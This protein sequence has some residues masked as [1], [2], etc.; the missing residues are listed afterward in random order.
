MR[1]VEKPTVVGDHSP[2]EAWDALRADPS[3]FMVDVRTD[4]EWA[5]VGCPD[6]SSAGKPLWRLSWRSFPDMSLNQG[7]VTELVDLAESAGATTVFFICRSGARSLEAACAVEALAPNAR[8]MTLANVA[9]GFE[10][11]LDATGKRGRD[12]G[13]KARGLPWRQT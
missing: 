13:W 4:A 10:G 2:V 3:S 8:A 9:E 11:D 12:T 6:L 5:F 1:A 7:F